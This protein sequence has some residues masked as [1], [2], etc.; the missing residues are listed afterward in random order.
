MN[1]SSGFIFQLIELRICDNREKNDFKTFIDFETFIKHKYWF[2][3]LFFLQIRQKSYF[4]SKRNYVWVETKL[5]LGQNRTMFGSKW[6]YVW[7]QTELCLGQ[8]RTMF[9]S[10]RNYV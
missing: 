2:V 10:K 4:G 3:V 8:N 9:G 7:V 6:N 5:C 1:T